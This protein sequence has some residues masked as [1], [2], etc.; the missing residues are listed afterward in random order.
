MAALFPPRATKWGRGVLIGGGLALLL[1]PVAAMAWVRTSWARGEHIVVQQPI[2]FSHALHA[3]TFA[4]DCRFCH[5]E[6]EWSAN[7]GM[8]PTDR[9]V[10]CHTPLWRS[11]AVLT[12]VRTSL[13]TGTPIPWRRVTQLPAFVYFNHAMHVSNGVACAT[14]HG[15]VAHMTV[16]R[17]VVP[18]TM[19]WCVDCHRD[20]WPHLPSQ[21]AAVTVVASQASSLPTAR[22]GLIAEYRIHQFTNC[23]TC[24]R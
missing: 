8:P 22:T 11:T 2:P 12:P 18:L 1:V 5:S 16:V 4:I 3:G 13:A 6:V 21:P 14:C 24:H 20:P 19:Q 9:C 7:A 23:T 10:T 17:Q 15:D